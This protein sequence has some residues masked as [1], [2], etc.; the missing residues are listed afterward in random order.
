VVHSCNTNYSGGRDRKI[1]NSRPVR[2][3][4]ED[5]SQ[6]QK[7]TN[8]S[9]GDAAQ[10]IHPLPSMPDILDSDPNTRGVKKK[11]TI[12]YNIFFFFLLWPYW[13]LNSGFTL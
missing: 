8:K 5:L 10:V 13:C 1:V 4:Y 2:K 7:N 9:V 6:K 11:V 12:D 3:S